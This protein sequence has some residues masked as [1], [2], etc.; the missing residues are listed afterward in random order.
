MLIWPAIQPPVAAH[1]VELLIPYPFVAVTELMDQRRYRFPVFISHSSKRPETS[2]LLEAVAGEL[3][4]RGYHPVYD[5]AEIRDGDEWATLLRYWLGHC[6]AA[7]LLLSQEALTNSPWVRYEASLLSWRNA[8]NARFRFITVVLD[9]IDKVALAQLGPLGLGDRQLVVPQYQ[10]LQA[11]CAGV[12]AR[13]CAAFPDAAHIS[14]VEDR[15]LAWIEDVA[16]LLRRADPAHVLRAARC[17]SVEADYLA[18]AD[19][20]TWLAA[21]ML[22]HRPDELVAACEALE[23]L[24]REMLEQLVERLAPNWVDPGAA[25]SVLA[26]TEPQGPRRLALNVASQDT[27]EVVVRRAYC[28]RRGFVLVCVSGVTGEDGGADYHEQVLQAYQRMFNYRGDA[29]A[30]RRQWDTEQRPI[31]L[32]LFKQGL[33]Q[34]ALDAIRDLID[35]AALLI[36]TGGPEEPAPVLDQAICS[37]I[38][39]PFA[40]DQEINGFNAAQTLRQL[41]HR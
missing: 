6:E 33:T 27:A 18:D 8:L 19:I 1:A 40:P 24:P 35:R 3:R 10:D 30:C 21:R 16:S 36:L 4:R 23:S 11:E 22:L 2:A 29:A 31:F 25:A 41:C 12:A 7:I 13:A 20:H 9:G 14:W 38:D 5:R 26:L 28:S 32:G 34:Q 17:L 15:M 39:P 37:M